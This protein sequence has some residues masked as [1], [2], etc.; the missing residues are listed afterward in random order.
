M[1]LDY[2]NKRGEFFVVPETMFEAEWI[3]ATFR[4]L[5]GKRTFEAVAFCDGD[6]LDL[7]AQG[8][9]FAPVKETT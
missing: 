1:R 7:N 9:R 3:T 2:N 4:G 6:P 5:K 8:L